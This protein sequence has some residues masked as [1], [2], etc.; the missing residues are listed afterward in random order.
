MTDSAAQ[1]K[2]KERTFEYL[3]NMMY[4]VTVCDM[5]CRDIGASRFSGRV[6]DGCTRMVSGLLGFVA[7][8]NDSISTAE[9][10]QKAREDD[11]NT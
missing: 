7:A 11:S 3:S 4:Y 10:V 5:K 6:F 8:F 9:V 2:H 1:T